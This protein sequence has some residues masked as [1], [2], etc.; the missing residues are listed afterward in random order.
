V[1]QLQQ[2][3]SGQLTNDLLGTYVANLQ[4]EAGVRSNTNALQQALGSAQSD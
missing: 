2:Q 1:A 4:T 3:L